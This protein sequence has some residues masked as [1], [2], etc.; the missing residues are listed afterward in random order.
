MQLR[1][2]FSFKKLFLNFF[3]FCLN[4]SLLIFSYVIL[5]LLSN[6]KN[7][8][9]ESNILSLPW[10]QSFQRFLCA[11]PGSNEDRDL[12]KELLQLLSLLIKLFKVTGILYICTHLT[13]YMGLS[14]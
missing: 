7:H 3:L 10:Q 14:C 6:D 13:L 8:L 1:S 12:L 5:D 2:F 11:P 4:V 9:S